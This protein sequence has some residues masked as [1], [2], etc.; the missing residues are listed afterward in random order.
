VKDWYEEWFGEE[1]LALYP[2]RDDEEAREVAALIASR[3]D[4]PAGAP[5]LDLA[6]GSG[7][8]QRALA[9]RWWTIG[10]D[11]SR[12]LLRVARDEDSQAPL[13]RADMRQ[14]PFADASFSLVTNLFT[15]FGYFRDESQHMRVIAEV[16]RVT[17]RG[18]WFVLDFLNAPQV[19]RSLISFDRRTE[20]GRV[21]EQTRE[22]SGDGRFVRKTITVSDEDRE[23][24]ERVRLFDPHELTEMVERAGFDV[25]EMLGGYD[26]Q[27]RADDSPRAIVVGARR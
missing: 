20:G 14:L 6:C 19:R 27:P 5:A 12:L 1:Y 16:A 18:G 9:E 3:I 24:V 10:L 11:L 4:V 23:F 13:I 2:H 7:R 22:I 26:G 8:H 17:R 15:S 21:I 25:I